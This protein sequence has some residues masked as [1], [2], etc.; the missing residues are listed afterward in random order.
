MAEAKS[1]ADPDRNLARP[2]E[3]SVLNSGDF[4][5]RMGQVDSY[6]EDLEVGQELAPGAVL[7]GRYEVISVIGSGGMGVVYKV[8][9]PYLR[10][11]FALKTVRSPYLSEQAITRFRKEAKAAGALDHPGLVAVHDFG[12]LED[13]QPFLVMDLIET[14]SLWDAIKQCGQLPEERVLDIFEQAC[15]ALA[16]AHEHK[17]IHRDLKPGNILLDKDEDGHE[18]VRIADFGVA[19]ILE[20]DSGA[21]LRLTQTGDMLGSPLYMSPEQCAG[22]I[23]DERSD[24]YSLACSMF[25]ALAGRPPFRGESALSTLLLHQKE[26]LPTLSEASG[27]P[28]SERLED[29]FARAMAKEPEQRYQSMGALKQELSTVRAGE[30]EGV[31]HTTFRRREKVRPVEEKV[32]VPLPVVLTSTLTVVI[33]SS[34]ATFLIV[35]SMQPKPLITL[36]QKPIVVAGERIPKVLQK[37]TKSGSKRIFHFPENYALGTL[38]SVLNGADVPIGH[39]IGT[40]EVPL[41]DELKFR[42]NW[43]VCEIPYVFDVFADDDLVYLDFSN[44]PVT[45]KVI[46]H[47]GRLKS[48]RTINLLNTE[49]T[50]RGLQNLLGMPCIEDLSLANTDVTSQGLASLTRIKG[51]RNLTINN[52]QLDERALPFFRNATSIVHLSVKNTGIKDSTLQL[53]ASNMKSLRS[54]TVSDNSYVTTDGLKYLVAVPHLNELGISNCKGIVPA[55]AITYLQL[56]PELTE[57]RV[58]QRDW[59]EWQAVGLSAKLPRC[60]FIQEETGLKR[61]LSID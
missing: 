7:S 57:L 19:K 5:K 34:L 47:I 23:A 61:R 52:L 14:G 13:G 8:K 20:D 59:K 45:D 55:E 16:H 10:K 33:L 60:N 31:K 54:L 3:G 51:L 40:I 50:D 28:Y 6:G 21:S 46:E 18:R 11:Y 2:K 44:L 26:P 35:K 36:P 38:Y 4:A 48:L 42:P 41:K 27:K 9:Q 56:M 39:A 32:I 12:L 58:L 22:K 25:E 49:I 17:I 1:E 29:L 15:D 30:P 37:T 43:A 53:I 24:I